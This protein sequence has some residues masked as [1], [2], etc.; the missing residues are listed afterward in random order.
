MEELPLPLDMVQ[1]NYSV[2]MGI[3][4]K[5]ICKSQCSSHIHSNGTLHVNRKCNSGTHKRPQTAKVI[6]KIKSNAGGVTTWSQ[7]TTWSHGDKTYMILSQKQTWHPMEESR[8]SKSRPTPPK[9]WCQKH[10]LEQRQP[11]QPGVLRKLDLQ[12]EKW[13]R[14]PLSLFHSVKNTIR[15][16]QRP[17]FQTPNWIC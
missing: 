16:H 7:I 4:L 15:I 1:R 2:K 12:V 6:L 17:S 14:I 10:T 3:L 5:G 9:A 11:H 8:G 13:M